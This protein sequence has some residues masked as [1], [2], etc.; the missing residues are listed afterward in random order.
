M[1]AAVHTLATVFAYNNL[2]I[3]F[4]SLEPTVEH[5]SSFISATSATAIPLFGVA[6]PEAFWSL[7]HYWEKDPKNPSPSAQPIKINLDNLSAFHLHSL[8]RKA[9]GQKLSPLL[10]NYAWHICDILIWWGEHLG[11]PTTVNQIPLHQTMQILSWSMN[12]KELTPDGNVEVLESPL[13]QGGIGEPEDKKFDAE[14]DVDMS[15]HILLIHGD[16]L[17]KEQLDTVQ[18]S[19]IIE[20]TPKWHFQYVVF[21]PG[22][23]HFKMACADVLWRTWVQLKDL[24]VDE[25]SLFQHI[26]ILR[27][28]DTGK[29]GTNMGFHWIHDV[30]HH[31]AWASML[32]CWQ[33]EV[34]AWE[35]NW[36]S[37]ADFARSK[38]S[39]DLIVE[40]SESIVQKYVATTSI[41][42]KARLKSR[43]EWDKVFENQ[44]LHNCDELLYLELSH[45]M[46]AGDVDQVE[47]TFLLWIYMFKATGK[48]KYGSQMLQF[49]VKMQDVYDEVLQCIMCVE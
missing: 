7:Q 14:N 10:A 5:P 42:S 38:L 19:W 40:I 12:I 25:N 49:M 4:K 20:A 32:D 1:K 18:D 43:N 34:I 16:L 33:L 26:G 9:L 41:I 3:H 27:L 17:T 21:L 13:H 11:Q 45:A 39:W 15:E 29:F 36:A 30:I 24:Q 35:S 28:D 37:I 46:N 8:S 23:F 47:V 2:D 6:N 44:V 48:H 22:L 31:D